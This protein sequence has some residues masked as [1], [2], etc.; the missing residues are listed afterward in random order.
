MIKKNNSH[1]FDGDQKHFTSE[2]EELKDITPAE[3]ACTLTASCPAIFENARANN[4]VIIGKVRSKCA[5]L[6]G[7]V[8]ADEMAIEISADL[9][10]VAL[11]I[12]P[13]K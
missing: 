2:L 10:R 4:F 12:P 1:S 6:E 9:I 7:R 3:F 13:N 5:A 11:G 8:G